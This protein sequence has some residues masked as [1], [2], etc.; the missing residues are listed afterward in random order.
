MADFSSN[1]PQILQSQAQKE[2]LANALFDAAS[3][4]MLYGRNAITSLGLVWGYLGGRV[5]L[6]GVPVLIPNGTLTL[7]A[8][9]THFIEVSATGA[10]SSNISGFAPDRVPLYRVVT[11]AVSVTS[12]EDHRSTLLLSRLFY[13]RAVVPLRD[14]DLMLTLAQALCQS[15]EFSGALTAPRTITF[16]SVARSLIVAVTTTGGQGVVLKTANGAA[17][18]LVDGQ[19]RLIEC[20]GLNVLAVG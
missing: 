11:G 18:P 14:A 3:P 16:P 13:G 2:V 20:D 17:L 19:R 9:L 8:N 15:L 6:N 1:I 5:Y 7:A 10:V 12:Y 4:A